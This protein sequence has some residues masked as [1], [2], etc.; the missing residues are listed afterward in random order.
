MML[1]PKFIGNFDIPKVLDSP[2]KRTA[3]I[4]P[5]YMDVIEK[6]LTN[7]SVKKAVGVISSTERSYFVSQITQHN[8]FPGLGLINFHQDPPHNLLGALPNGEIL[9]IQIC[10]LLTPFTKENGGTIWI[11]S[12]PTWEGDF[13]NEEKSFN[14][15]TGEPGDVYWWPATLLH[16]EGVNRTNTTRS[17][18]IINIQSTTVEDS[19][20]KLGYDRPIMSLY[21]QYM[22]HLRCSSSVFEIDHLNKRLILVDRF[23]D[24]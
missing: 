24:S 19:G 22:A 4:L 15:V 9:G 21:D 7:P 16:S 8:L 10:V 18:L 12:L 6:I 17:C 11:N 13:S 1:A 5:F 23:F 2:H 3:N 14:F 20:F